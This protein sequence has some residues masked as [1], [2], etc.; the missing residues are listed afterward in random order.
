MT[1]KIF[2]LFD[3]S[4][5]L[6]IITVIPKFDLSKNIFCHGVNPFKKVLA[7]KV[8]VINRDKESFFLF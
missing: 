2:F 7:L 1:K 6:I 8:I 5:V 3:K 4:K